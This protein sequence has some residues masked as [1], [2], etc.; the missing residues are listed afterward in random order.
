MY[1][2]FPWVGSLAGARILYLAGA[3]QVTHSGAATDDLLEDG[4]EA[5]ASEG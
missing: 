5:D 3:R 1:V 2:R 4:K